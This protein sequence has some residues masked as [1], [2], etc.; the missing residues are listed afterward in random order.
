ML[1]TF[2]SNFGR[3]WLKSQRP[4]PD[5][6]TQPDD[7]N[8]P[9]EDKV[10]EAGE[11][12]NEEVT[13]EQLSPGELEGEVINHEVEKPDISSLSAV[14]F[15]VE[16]P[17][18][19]FPSPGETTLVETEDEVPVNMETDS[20][21]QEVSLLEIEATALAANS[22]EVDSENDSLMH[23]AELTSDHPELPLM[24]STKVTDTVKDEAES[25]SALEEDVTEGALTSSIK[26][27]EMEA[28]SLE[29]SVK[30][31]VQEN[32]R[33]T[34]LLP[35]VALE[36][37]HESVAMIQPLKSEISNLEVLEAKMETLVAAMNNQKVEMVNLVEEGSAESSG[38]VE[39]VQ[40]AVVVKKPAAEIEGTL[41]GDSEA[42]VDVAS[43]AENDNKGKPA[44]DTVLPPAKEFCTSPIEE[45]LVSSQPIPALNEETSDKAPAKEGAA[46]PIGEA[47][48]TLAIIT[49]LDGMEEKELAFVQPQEKIL[50]EVKSS[51][52]KKQEKESVAVG[53]IPGKHAQIADPAEVELS[54]PADSAK[55]TE[56][57]NVKPGEELAEA[58]AVLKKYGIKL[59]RKY[60]SE[61]QGDVTV[62]ITKQK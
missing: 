48:S 2:F 16:E 26:V 14:E 38:N 40:V 9:D 21:E 1:S 11:S 28:N 52:S 7:S 35:E 27:A 43:L 60:D 31:Q 51:S 58:N 8:N 45:A 20:I 42:T 13:E 22:E 49:D 39:V 30:N 19:T 23:A 12:G 41:I 37:R 46:D 32:V 17:E 36:E 25:V 44:E 5:Q 3:P 57:F 62:K 33:D 55:S 4:I 56:I 15:G 59:K 6:K 24:D 29:A 34:A 53:H 47:S 54:R 18:E 61:D 50:D 10:E